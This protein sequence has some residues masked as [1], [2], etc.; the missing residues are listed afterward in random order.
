[1]DTYRKKRLARF[2]SPLLGS[3]TY[4]M[5]A[6]SHASRR[7]LNEPDA[8][9]QAAEALRALV[10]E[11]RLTP[12]PDGVLQIE[13]AGDLAGILALT[14][15]GKKPATMSRDGLASNVGCGD[16][17]PLIPNFSRV[18]WIVSRAMNSR[19]VA[20]SH[21]GSDDAEHQAIREAFPEACGCHGVTAGRIWN[22]PA[23]STASHKSA[24]VS[25]N[26]AKG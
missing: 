2:S 7:A 6:R 20:Y 8:R 22:S 5:P 24:C 19:T 16:P 26:S 4:L 21:V 23:L 17:Q 15:N 12:A 25:A 13:L 11:I 3:F 14:A 18:Q 1:M 9:E 10:D